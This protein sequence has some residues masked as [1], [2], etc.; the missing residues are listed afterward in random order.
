MMVYCIEY[1]HDGKS[2]LHIAAERGDVETVKG[3]LQHPGIKLN[4]ETMVRTAAF[5]CYKKL[6]ILTVEVYLNF[7]V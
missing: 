4:Q 2:L 1:L 3:L 6:I 7:V 5:F